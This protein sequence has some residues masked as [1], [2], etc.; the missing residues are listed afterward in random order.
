M[1]IDHEQKQVHFTVVFWGPHYSGKTTAL[2]FISEQLTGEALALDTG[3]ELDDHA[4]RGTASWDSIPF[5][6]GEVGGYAISFRLDST[7]ERPFVPL[8]RLQ[9]AVTGADGL[10]LVI[11]SR[12]E[13]LERNRRSLAKLRQA[14]QAVGSSLEALPVVVMYNRQDAPTALPVEQLRAALGLT[15]FQETTAIASRGV[16]VFAALKQIVALVLARAREEAN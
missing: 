1:R 8:P 10:V 16:G 12:A 7:C 6:A 14:L 2:S 5:A 4:E 9:V 11:Y 15:S 13:R 3:D